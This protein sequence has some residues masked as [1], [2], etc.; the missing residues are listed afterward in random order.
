MIM[1][2][3]EIQPVADMSFEQAMAE[4]ERIVRGL[5]QGDIG[6]EESIT[7]YERGAALRKH[8]EEKLSSAQAR[9]DKITVGADGIPKAEPA[10]ID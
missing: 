1:T 4:L 3:E 7:A 6:L 9:I 10:R 2:T 8:C 5:E